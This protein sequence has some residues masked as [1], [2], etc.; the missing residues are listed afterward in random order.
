VRLLRTLG[1]QWAGGPRPQF[2][3]RG[4]NED[5]WLLNGGSIH[6]RFWTSERRASFLVEAKRFLPDQW[7]EVAQSDSD[8][9]QQE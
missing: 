6:L 7:S 1:Q 9:V 3:W 8:P 2:G 4:A 5:D